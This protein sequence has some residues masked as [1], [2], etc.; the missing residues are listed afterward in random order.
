MKIR[1][2]LL[3]T[4]CGAMA[5]GARA[6]EEPLVPVTDASLLNAQQL[7]TL[8]GPIAL[9]PDALIA[10]ILPASTA[11]ADVVLAARYLKD[12][13]DPADVGSR[14]WDDSVKS[15]VHYPA[16]LRWMDDNLSWTKQLGEAFRDQP[17]EVMKAVQRL[18]ARARAIGA[19]TDTAQQTVVL[20]GDLITIVPAQ[21]DAI[22]VPY[23]DPDM[24]Y[25]RPAGY[26]NSPFL[27]FSPAFAVGPWLAFDCDWR[28]HTVWTVERHW[29]H[30]GNRDWR[31]PVFPGQPGFVN[32]PS[33]HPWKPVANFPRPAFTNAPRPRD[34]IIRPAAPNPTTAGLRADFAA[35][36]GEGRNNEPGGN[37]P[38]VATTTV[39]GPAP[40]TPVAPTPSNVTP[41]PAVAPQPGRHSDPSRDQ[42]A[43]RPVTLPS[44]PPPAQTAAA[45][46]HYVPTS[47]TPVVAQFHGPLVPVAAPPPPMTH[48]PVAAAPPPPS[49]PP[50]APTPPSAAPQR[51]VGDTDRKAQPN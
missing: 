41:P 5:L 39:V 44:T 8:L 46:S 48:A 21:P 16:I 7:D 22:Y 20:D 51:G 50:S 9:Y 28:H 26:Y 18:R 14:S 6:Q 35:R 38:A 15:L 36:R 25:V 11:P 24:V 45:P 3:L 33:R 40:V 32:D 2:H 1:L 30:P 17:D 10:L 47:A 23:Y 4:L 27:S 37:L 31:H 34:E 12:N 19:L 43:N 49:A 13:G 42:I 29:N